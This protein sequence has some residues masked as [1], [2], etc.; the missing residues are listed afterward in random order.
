MYF[1]TSVLAL[2][3]FIFVNDLLFAVLVKDFIDVVARSGGRVRDSVG[4]GD[5][6]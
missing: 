4:V 6:V 1:I 2:F 3:W 5:V